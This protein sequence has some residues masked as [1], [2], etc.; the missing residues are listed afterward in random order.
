MEHPD[1][2]SAHCTPPGPVLLS[3]YRLPREIL[4]GIQKYA[5]LWP[6]PIPP[7]PVE[8]GVHTIAN[9]YVDVE[10]SGDLGRAVFVPRELVE[11]T[12]CGTLNV[13]YD[14]FISQK[15]FCNTP[16]GKF[17]CQERRP[18]TVHVWHVMNSCCCV[19]RLS[20]T[21]V[22]CSPCMAGILP[23]AGSCVGMPLFCTKRFPVIPPFGL[24][25]LAVPNSTEF[26]TYN[27]TAG[28]LN[29]QLE[30]RD[31]LGSISVDECTVLV[32]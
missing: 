17:C 9:E 15:D 11:Q 7:G 25:E 24:T 3:Y 28:Y 1:R 29:I 4:S 16:I 22:L 8:S 6:P 30:A 32:G 27:E 12:G 31:G 5:F 2:T 21:L 18:C 13:T 20:P 23:H 26:G 14:Q 10:A 19:C